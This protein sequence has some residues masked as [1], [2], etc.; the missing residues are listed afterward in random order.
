MPLILDINVLHNIFEQKSNQSIAFSLV[1]QWLRKPVS[2]IATG[3][4]KYNKELL[5]TRKYIPF[6]IELD[7]KRKVVK[8]SDAEVDKKAKQ[9]KKIVND[10]DFDDEHLIAIA[11][12]AKAFAVC[13]ND[14]RA[15]KFIKEAKLYPKNFT[16]PKIIKKTTREN[17]VKKILS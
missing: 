2:K 8:L 11:I 14:A 5:E 15:E 12:L 16:R 17:D 9:V 7:K 13:T 10:T 3:G 4:T 6:F 1:D